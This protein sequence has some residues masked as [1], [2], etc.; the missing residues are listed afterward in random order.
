MA[1]LR[2]I[3]GDVILTPTGANSLP[4][5]EI[6]SDS[7]RGF[8]LLVALYIPDAHSSRAIAYIESSPGPIAISPLSIVE[9]SNAIQVRVFRKDRT[10]GQ[11]RESILAFEGDISSGVLNVQPIP[12]AV[13]ELAERLATCTR[14]P[15][16]P[17]RSTFS[18]CRS[19]S[20]FAPNRSSLSTA[21]RPN[22]PGSPA[23]KRSRTDRSQK[24]RITEPCTFSSARQFRVIL[25]TSAWR[26]ATCFLYGHLCRDQWRGP[27]QPPVGSLR[28][29]PRLPHPLRAGWRRTR[30]TR[31]GRRFTSN[32]SAAALPSVSTK[33]CVMTLCC[34]ASK[35]AFRGFCAISGPT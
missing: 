24:D 5:T 7:L 12:P 26:P 3:H 10:P 27:H 34:G 23:S 9:T 33:G 2:R 11:A 17:D 4:K 21:G 19:R 30:E 32:W 35:A 1:R 13:W 22:W 8:G 31:K 14:P 18:R 6:A 16:E 29:A 20:P 15:S 28:A 25:P